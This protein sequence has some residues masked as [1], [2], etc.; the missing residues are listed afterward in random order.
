MK[1]RNS[2]FLR[3]LVTNSM[4][5]FISV[6]LI[7][8]L[9]ITYT[10][11]VMTQKVGILTTSI[12]EQM[13]LSIDNYFDEIEEVGTLV[14]ANEA[15]YK[16][17]ATQVD[18]S[19]EEA[20]YENIQTQNGIK[21]SL[22][23]VSLMKN[24]GDFGI[25]YA[26]NSVI[27]KTASNTND[28]FG[29]DTLYEK[30][31]AHIS[32]ATTQD[33]WFTGVDGNYKKLYYV[34]RVNDNAVLLTSLYTSELSNVLSSSDQLADMVLCLTDSNNV[35][36]YSND[37]EKIGTTIA[38]TVT[39]KMDG[40][41]HSTFIADGALT[42][43]TACN[44]NWKLLSSMETGT[45]LKE[46][47]QIKLFTVLISAA[48][49]LLAAVLAIISAR[50]IVKPL[51]ALMKNMKEVEEGNLNIHVENHSK[52]EVGQLTH[53]FNGM[54][55]N[56]RQLIGD[57]EGIANRVEDQAI[58]IRDAAQ[59]T[60]QIS[61]GVSAAVDGIAVEAVKQLEETQQTFESLEKLA[62]S[63]G[64]T[65][66][67][68][69]DMAAKSE[70]TK[71]IGEASIRN[72]DELQRTTDS[73]NETLHN[74]GVTVS[75]LV[76]EVQEVKAIV[77][78]IRNINEETNLLALNASI[79]AARAGEAGR[80]FAVVAN[81]V[82]KLA[83]QTNTATIEVDEVIS[84]IYQYGKQTDTV[85]NE[86][87]AVFAQQK[88]IVEDSN[89]SFRAILDA[90]ILITE[91]IKEIQKMTEEMQI[92]KD[93]SLQATNTILEAA[94]TSSANAEEVLSTSDE[95][96]DATEKLFEKANQ[97]STAVDNLQQSLS[98]FKVK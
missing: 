74:V 31:S 48:C 1:R 60:Q 12:N 86:S 32:D 54:I 47:N 75:Q 43:Y 90:T 44:G 30:V 15:N 55:A 46:M 27:G 9:S 68:V 51:R 89:E 95:E 42:S 16:Y 76:N 83:D 81:Q 45:I 87:E 4:I 97:L 70:E 80:G 72:V 39:A 5:V 21:D 3:M 28:L 6:L 88:K 52:D 59:K 18:N 57:V 17:D 64:Q 78:M 71:K 37:E 79:E 22:L 66:E 93:H 63:I 84:R 29:K 92:Q 7:A 94:E 91:K 14:F 11:N 61:E 26:D 36:I 58:D 23:S 69:S 73:A 20:K 2:L 98:M 34:K 62:G 67:Y 56:I 96:H 49:I 13:C 38:S 77:E 35:V 25:I 24:F 41:N 50:S 85:I 33:G 65:I 8:V 40:K 82:Q 53:S 19:N 10:S